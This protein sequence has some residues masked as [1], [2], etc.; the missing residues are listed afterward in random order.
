MRRER[1][2]IDMWMVN[3]ADDRGEVRRCRMMGTLFAARSYAAE[4]SSAETKRLNMA[5]ARAMKGPGALLGVM[6]GLAIVAW[7]AWIGKSFTSAWLATL[8]QLS[9]IPVVWLVWDLTVLQTRVRPKYASERRRIALEIERC[10]W[11]MYRLLDTP[12]GGVTCPECGESGSENFRPHLMLYAIARDKFGTGM[13]PLR[14]GQGLVPGD[15][16]L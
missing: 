8:S 3:I 2:I 4:V 12:G 14:I 9:V 10:P 15:A 13:I 16:W 7:N 5:A 6:I 1:P 11:C